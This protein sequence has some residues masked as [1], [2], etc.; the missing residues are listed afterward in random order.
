MTLEHFKTEIMEGEG[1][2]RIGDGLRLMD[3]EARHRGCLL[4]GQVPLHEAVHVADGRESVDNQRAVGLRLGHRRG[5]VGLVG[6]VADDLLNDVFQREQPHHLTVLVDD[7][8]EMGFA[9]EK[10]VELIL[11]RRGLGHEPWRLDQR[12][13]VDL[14]DVAAGIAQSS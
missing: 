1:L 9:L 13:D 2:F 5:D 7:D 12:H 3:D 11:D 8:R 10:R 4:V 14:A 6:D